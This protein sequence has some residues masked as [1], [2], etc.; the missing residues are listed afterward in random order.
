MQQ[1]HNQV[2]EVETV[3]KV[4]G[5]LLLFGLLQHYWRQPWDLLD[6]VKPNQPIK[7]EVGFHTFATLQVVSVSSWFYDVLWMVFLLVGE[8]WEPLPNETWKLP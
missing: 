6:F 5:T 2:W 7:T 1:N 3:S 8:C 4:A